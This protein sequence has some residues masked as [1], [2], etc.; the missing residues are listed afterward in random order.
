MQQTQAPDDRVSR[1]RYERE[2]RAREEAEQLLEAKSRELYE[3]NLALKGQT[4][5]LEEAVRARTSDLEVAR[6][7]AVEA[8][9]R[10]EAASHAKSEFLATMSHEIRTPLNGVLGVAAALGETNLTSEQRDMLQIVIESGRGLFA[11]I[12]DILDLSKIEARKLDI[13]STPFELLQHLRMTV[14]PYEQMAL[15]KGID[16]RLTLPDSD[17]L[18]ISSDQTRLRQVLGN[19]V[20][21]AVK[22]TEDGAV[23]VTVHLSPT[24]K[25]SNRI[26]QIEVLDSGIGVPEDKRHLLF[27]PFQQAES[28]TTRRFGGTG[29]GLSI[30]RRICLLMGG[31]L[32]HAPAPGG[33]SI[34]L[35]RFLTQDAKPAKAKKKRHLAEAEAKLAAR[36]RRILVAEDNKTNQIVLHHMLKRYALE[37]V[38]VTDGTQ[39]VQAWSRGGIDLVLMDLNMPVMGGLDATDK[40]REQ[41]KVQTGPRTP[42]IALSANAMAHQIEDCVA[43]DMDDHLAKPVNREAL[44]LCLSQ[45][46][47]P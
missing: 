2:R 30:S 7:D 23:T 34:F 31:D 26:L 43:H 47:S 46:L 35:A 33:G 28:S 27:N 22:F 8:Q 4:E 42:I 14:R 12:N 11:I 41:E 19:L 15:D 29:L 39:A 25:A 9:Q 5:S 24:D 1:R 40:I 20:S 17:E 44:V 10:A 18:W 32:T 6:R 38:F 45:H 21:N 37:L 13:E 36:P 16:L 3:T